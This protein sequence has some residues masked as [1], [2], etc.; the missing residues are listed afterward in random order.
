MEDEEKLK[1]ITKLLEQG[2]TMLATHHSCGAPLFRCKGQVICPICSSS[3]EDN[4]EARKIASVSDVGQEFVTLDL[5]SNAEK[6]ESHENALGSIPK[7][8]DNIEEIGRTK[9]ALRVALMHKLKDLQKRME[10]EEDLDRLS[11]L[12]QCME[13][14]LKI[15]KILE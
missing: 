15:L 5:S 8:I 14:I 9:N 13:G 4:A 11:R 3:Q 12:L 2:C 7:Q 1:K 6:K 10:E